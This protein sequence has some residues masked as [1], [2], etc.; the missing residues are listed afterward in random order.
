MSKSAPK[1]L[2][3]TIGFPTLADWEAEGSPLFA[4]CKTC[5]REVCL[6]PR[7]YTMRFGRQT[8]FWRIMKRLRCTICRAPANIRRVPSGQVTP[9]FIQVFGR[10]AEAEV[11]VFDAMLSRADEAKASDG[12]NRETRT[13]RAGRARR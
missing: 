6:M 9:N 2:P 12:D 8:S 10:D 11:E 3:A 5:G 4:Q 1:A 13:S 7:S